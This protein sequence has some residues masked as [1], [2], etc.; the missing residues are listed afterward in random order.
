MSMGQWR[1]IWVLYQRKSPKWRWKITCWNTHICKTF[2]HKENQH[3]TEKARHVFASNALSLSSSWENIQRAQSWNCILKKPIWTISSIFFGTS[4]LTLDLALYMM[5]ANGID[6]LSLCY[7]ES[8]WTAPVL[9]M[10]SHMNINGNLEKPF[11]T[12]DIME[13][14]STYLTNHK[15]A[16]PLC[17]TTSPWETKKTHPPNR[18]L[19]K[20][21]SE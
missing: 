3:G 4:S 13:C 17:I 11:L 20:I 15:I 14:S 16:N 21:I 7:W 19:Q 18:Q 5:T 6:I 10:L 9:K 12:M 2:W 8:V 1:E